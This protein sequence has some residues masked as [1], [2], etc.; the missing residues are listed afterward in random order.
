MEQSNCIFCK[1]T[2][3]DIPSSTIYEDNYFKVILD[4]SPASKGHAI[5]IPKK[6][7]ENIFELDETY[8]SKIFVVAKKVAKA[9][10]EELNCDGFN[11]LQNNGEV[12]GQSVFHFHMHLIPRYKGDNITIK[13]CLGKYE[14][15][16]L[17]NLA[18]A[19]SKRVQ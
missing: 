16:D 15:E 18:S 13:W 7:A 12:A 17:T 3:G 9:M 2:T 5:I 8:A 1:I 4:I 11:I 14:G 10:K 6:H 19:I